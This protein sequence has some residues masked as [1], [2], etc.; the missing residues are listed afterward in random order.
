LLAYLTAL[1]LLSRDRLMGAGRTLQE[2][3]R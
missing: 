1:M 3:I 2:C